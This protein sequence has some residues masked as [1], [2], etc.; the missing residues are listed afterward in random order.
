MHKIVHKTLA[1]FRMN[2]LI[3]V[4]LI[5]TVAALLTHKYGLNSLYH[6]NMASYPYIVPTSDSLDGGNSVVS[7]QKTDSS[8]IMDYELREGMPYPYA[9]LQIY[10]G[11]GKTQGKD[12][13]VYD[14]VFLWIKPRGEG[15]VRLYL[16]GYDKDIYREGDLTSLKFNELEFFPLEEPYPAAFVPQEFRVAGWWVAQN[17][18]NVHKA[19][20]DISNVPLIEIQPIVSSL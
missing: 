15:S 7:L 14:S 20:V 11:D 16:R 3:L 10:L 19:R 9:G 6:I 13:S 17:S 12:L 18:V 5:F 8:I 2:V 1:L 4:L